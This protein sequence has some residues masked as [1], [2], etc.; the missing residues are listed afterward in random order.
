MGERPSGGGGGCDA[1]FNHGIDLQLRIMERIGDMT[2]E[3]RS[4]NLCIP[5]AEDGREICLRFS[6]KGDC[7][8]SCTHSRVPVQGHDCDSVI[9]Y[10]RVAKEA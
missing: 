10:I 3:A 1:I 7:V 9:R 6:S 8:I 5:L 4:E 2:G